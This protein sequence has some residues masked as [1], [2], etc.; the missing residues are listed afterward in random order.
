MID[1]FANILNELEIMIIAFVRNKLQKMYTKANNIF[2]NV[3]FEFFKNL[4]IFDWIMHIFG[5]REIQIS[6][7]DH[8]FVLNLNFL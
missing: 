2:K 1:N 7:Q 5:T 8:S 6:N 3:I 4:S